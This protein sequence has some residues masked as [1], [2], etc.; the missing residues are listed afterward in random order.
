MN[1]GEESPAITGPPLVN[2]WGT[3]RVT[4]DRPIY[5]GLQSM[6]PVTPS[7]GSG[8]ASTGKPPD[9]E[10]VLRRLISRVVGPESTGRPTQ[11]GLKQRRNFSLSRTEGRV[12][13]CF[14]CGQSGHG[15]SWCPRIDVA[16]PLFIAEM[17]GGTPGWSVP[18]SLAEENAGMVSVR[19]R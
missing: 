3:P 19:I 13:V 6:D 18:G 5:T 16:F 4:E 14:S 12:M 8:T 9:I 10:E 2:S 1:C 11:E 17:V 15:V 7:R